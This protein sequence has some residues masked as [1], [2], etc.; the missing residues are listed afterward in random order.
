MST[1]ELLAQVRNQQA[2]GLEDKV[3][4]LGQLLHQGQSGRRR[5]VITVG[6]SHYALRMNTDLKLFQFST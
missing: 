4:V 5:L 1:V 6:D 2:E 3:M